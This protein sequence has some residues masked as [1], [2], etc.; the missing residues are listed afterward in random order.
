MARLAGTARRHV[1]ERSPRDVAVSELVDIASE[2]GWL[3]VDLL[4]ATAGSELG[5]WQHS[6]TSY[7][8]GELTAQLLV[9]AGADRVRVEQ[10]AAITRAHLAIASGPGIGHS[11]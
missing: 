8:A 5:G 9:A 1:C 10:L 2:R 6:S 4:E 3:R 7:W 11:A